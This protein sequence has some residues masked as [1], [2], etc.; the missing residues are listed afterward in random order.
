MPE[1][2]VHL[3]SES[4]KKRRKKKTRATP[5]A[6]TAEDAVAGA[7]DWCTIA[8]FSCAASCD[9]SRVEHIVVLEEV[10]VEAVGGSTAGAAGAIRKAAP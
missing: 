5:S 4:A 8:L 6:D 7:P 1:L 9:E 2:L 10:D 3:R